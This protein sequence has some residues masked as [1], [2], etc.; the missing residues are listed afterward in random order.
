MT[1]LDIIDVNSVLHSAH[2]VPHLGSDRVNGCPT[3]GLVVL[4]RKVSYLLSSGH[5]VVCVFDSSTD[6]KIILPEYK[7]N[8]VKVPEVILQSEL[9]YKL[10]TDL[11][12]SC[13]KVNGFEADDLIYN[14][15]N[16]YGVV[17]PR[18]Y[19]HS[20]DAD[21]AHNVINTRIE[22]L[23]VNSNSYMINYNNFVEVFSEEDFRLPKNMITLKKVLLGDK[24][25]N[26]KPFT[27]ENGMTGRKMLKRILELTE[28]CDAYDPELNRTRGFAEIM[29]GELGLTEK[30]L[31]TLSKRC[32]VFFPK[33]CEV[34]DLVDPVEIKAVNISS[35]AG[36]LRAIRCFEGLRSLDLNASISP[37]TR[38]NEILMDYGKRF[39]SGEFHVDKDL[40]LHND[41]F[42]IDDSSVF[43]REL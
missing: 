10:L 34:S 42:N 21:L 29:F 38:V 20:S 35:F 32:D 24:S 11:N 17:T 7:A 43:I 19:I 2:N 25:D 31:E 12:I 9:A 6:R 33:E 30:D 18:V 27:S 23:P 15:C 22:V 36:T 26:V 4:F 1:Y 5:H 3:G 37:S 8:R 14:I 28:S 16:I 40:S 13:I 41:L 39:R